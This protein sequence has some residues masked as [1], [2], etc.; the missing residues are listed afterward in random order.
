MPTV[1]SNL[2]IHGGRSIPVVLNFP[3]LPCG[4]VISG[5][6][7]KSQNYR[8]GLLGIVSAAFRNF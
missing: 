2:Y 1:V 6:F 8:V 7:V 3:K 5:A 4:E